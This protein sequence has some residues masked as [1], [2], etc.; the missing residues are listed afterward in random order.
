M[1]RNYQNI[2]N[3][4][5][6]FKVHYIYKIFQP[7]NPIKYKKNKIQIKFK[8]KKTKKKEKIHNWKKKKINNQLFQEEN[9]K[10]PPVI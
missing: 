7:Q 2:T 6:K 9:K 1:N 3:Y 8:N 4:Q 5:P 10:N